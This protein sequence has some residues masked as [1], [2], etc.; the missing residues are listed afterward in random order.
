M[1]SRPKR[2]LTERRRHRPRRAVVDA[3]LAAVAAN[4]AI[5]AGWTQSTTLRVLAAMA[6]LFVT[7]AG[8]VAHV[9]LRPRVQPSLP[10]KGDFPFF[11]GRERELGELQERHDRRRDSLSAGPGASGPL[12]LAI[13]GRPGVGKTALAQQLA[14]RLADAY[15]DGLL[16]E[17]MGT[18]GGPRPPRDILHSLLRELRWPEEEMRGMSA[19]EL[20]GVFRAKTADKQMLIVLDA[21]RSFEQITAV[22]PGGNRCTVITTSRANLLA[23]RGQHSQRLGPVTAREAAEILLGSLGR[24]LTAKPDLVAEAIELCDFQPNALLS[25]G[26][27]A[28]NE[29]LKHAIDRLRPDESRLDVL[30]YGG[31]DV[32]ERIASQYNNLEALEK[33]AFLLLT[34]PESKTFVPW[35][36]QPLLDTGSTEAG[37]LMANISRVG[38]LELEGRDPSGFGRYRFSSLVRLFAEQRLREGNIVSPAEA[39]QARDRFRRAYLAGSVRVLGQLGVTGLPA[40]PAPV[41]DHW[42]PQVSEWEAKVAENLDAW[43][44]AEFGSLIRAVQDAASDGQ[45]TLCWQIAARLGDCFAPPTAHT[46]VRLAF[47]MALNAAQGSFGSPA[48]EIQVRVARSGYLAAVHDYSDA[49][50]ELKTVV[51]LA[52]GLDDQAAKAEGFRRLAHAWQEIADYDQALLMLKEGQSTVLHTNNRESRL[53][54]L[55]RA[56]NDAIR[57]PDYWI[58]EPSTAGLSQDLRDNSQ[59]IEKIILGRAARRRREDLTCEGL[60]KEARCYSSEN[61][62]HGLDIEHERATTLLHC[63]VSP[64]MTGASS[65]SQGA[66]LIISLAAQAVRSSDQLDRPHA[67]AQARCT[68]A[69]ALARAGQTEDCFVQLKLAEQIVQ[70]LQSEEAQRLNVRIQ[71]VRGEAL[72]RSHKARD[73]LA[74]LEPAER[75]LAQRESWAHAE[76]LVLLGTAHRELRQFGSALTAHAT[77]AEVFRQHRDKDATR[78]ALAELSATLRASGAGPLSVR[79]VRRALAQAGTVP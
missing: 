13:H 58:S 20:G 29:G 11:C 10:A 47:E 54:E 33:R 23:G 28:R 57:D 9:G 55:L 66:R 75:W 53:I 61:L 63:A 8:V 42:Y 78:V 36:L 2:Q 62:A 56:E 15:S 60:L 40:L 5:Y 1:T 46:D 43:V 14:L 48:A 26:D 68:L 7:G 22:L 59:F 67:R 17:N 3:V 64:T 34:L 72:L 76:I 49:I 65:N 30:R 21:A 27:R 32:A 35:A 19:A 6:F 44:R 71:R 12:L 70:T 69:H 41:P 25:V 37:N 45:P 50:T 79:R 16:Y 39:A 52:V 74:A 38:L 73:A 31:R 18:G 51:A 4:V 77:A 24:S